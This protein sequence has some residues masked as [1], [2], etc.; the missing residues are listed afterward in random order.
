[1]LELYLVQMVW[2]KIY[3]FY[4]LTQESCTINIL[5][6]FHTVRHRK[7]FASSLNRKIG[8]KIRYFVTG[9]KMFRT[10]C[11]ISYRAK[12][13]GP[14]THRD[15]KYLMPKHPHKVER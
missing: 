14:F 15:E 4:L 9:G 3:I 10:R 12:A 11:D 6:I 8:K 1:M 7:F 2:W 5:Q 13:I